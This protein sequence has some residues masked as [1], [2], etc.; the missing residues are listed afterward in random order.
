VAA[1]LVVLGCLVA[2]GALSATAFDKVT[3]LHEV[4]TYATIA[5]LGMLGA[6]LS[7]DPADW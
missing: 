5:L 1:L 3:V 7:F 4:G 2:A 6:L